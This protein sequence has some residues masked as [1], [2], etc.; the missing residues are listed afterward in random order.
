M[1]LVGASRAP[2]IIDIIPIVARETC[3]AFTPLNK[4]VST[5]KL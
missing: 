3:R 4:L 5:T 1:I 2:V